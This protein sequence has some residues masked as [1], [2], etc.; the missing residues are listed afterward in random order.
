MNNVIPLNGTALVQLDSFSDAELAAEAERGFALIEKGEDLKNEGWLIVG[1]VLL[2]LKKRHPKTNDFGE[3]ADEILKLQVATSEEPA[4]KNWR[5]A[6]IWAAEFPDQLAE[7]QAKFPDVTSLRGWHAKWRGISKQS[8]SPLRQ[9]QASVNSTDEIWEAFKI[10]AEAEGVSAAAKLGGMIADSVGIALPEPEPKK[11]KKAPKAK[12]AV[13]KPAVKKPAVKAKKGKALP[14]QP[15]PKGKPLTR[16]EVDPE[17][18][19]DGVAFAAKYGHVWTET[20]EQRATRRFGDWA[21]SMRYLVKAWNDPEIQPQEVDLNWLRSPK[22]DDFAKHSEA[23]LALL[24]LV[25]AAK[26]QFAKAKAELAK[27]VKTDA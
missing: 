6:A 27:K 2:E 14:P 11:A 20:A 9:H 10:A 21:R 8:E 13:K 16:E 15:Q 18:V 12:P 22:L 1:A 5:S 24:E 3:K 19:G 23:L 17:F 25:E 4:T 26:A 7:V